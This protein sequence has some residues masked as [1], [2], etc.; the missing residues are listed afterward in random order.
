MLHGTLVVNFPPPPSNRLWYGFRGNPNLRVKVKPKV[1]EYL[2]NFPRILEVIEK[3]IITEFQVSFHPSKLKISRDE[4]GGYGFRWIAIK[5]PLMLIIRPTRTDWRSECSVL[6]LRRG[7]CGLLAKHEGWHFRR[8]FCLR[9]FDYTD[10]ILVLH[11]SNLRWR[12]ETRITICAHL[13]IPVES[14]WIVFLCK[15]EMK[16]PQLLN[17]ALFSSCKDHFSSETKIVVRGESVCIA[18]N[19]VI[20][21]LVWEPFYLVPLQ[22]SKVCHWWWS[23]LIAVA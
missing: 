21:C 11:C 18:L 17:L 8:I 5:L 12:S 15:F 7:T 22:L 6:G 1:G 10:H 23:F 2:F 19:S 13:S 9:A 20:A 3:R 14:R 16:F 4:I